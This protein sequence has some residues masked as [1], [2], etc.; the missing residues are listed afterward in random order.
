MLQRQ[1]GDKLNDKEKVR[2]V[3]RTNIILQAAKKLPSQEREK[4]A[5]EVL[6]MNSKEE[7][8]NTTEQSS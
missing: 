6:E 1:G 4:I 7:E 2:D 8:T 5:A 3:I